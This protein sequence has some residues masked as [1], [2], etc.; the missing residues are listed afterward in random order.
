MLRLP[1]L[2][3][4]MMEET[5]VSVNDESYDY[6]SFD[7]NSDERPTERWAP[8]GAAAVSP[9]P[10]QTETSHHAQN[11]Q[12]RQ[13]EEEQEQLNSSLLALTTHFAHVQFRLK[14]IVSAP[15]DDKENWKSSLEVPDAKIGLDKKLRS[16]K[17]MMIKERCTETIEQRRQRGVNRH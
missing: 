15:P 11:D 17:E 4:R 1:W 7:E 10:S 9:A 6:D 14:Q 2:H 12:L 5:Q 8:L 13:L 3:F 16:S